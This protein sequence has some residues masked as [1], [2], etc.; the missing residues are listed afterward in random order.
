MCKARFHPLELSRY[1]WT[2]DLCSQNWQWVD[3]LILTKLQHLLND[4]Q[5]LNKINRQSHEGETLNMQIW[6]SLEKWS[7]MFC[8]FFICF[9]SVLNYMTYRLVNIIIMHYHN[10]NDICSKFSFTWILFFSLWFDAW[11]RSN[12]WL[13][14]QNLYSLYSW[15][16]M[17]GSIYAP[18]LYFS[19]FPLSC[20]HLSMIFLIFICSFNSFKSHDR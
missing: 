19:S 6:V 13:V 8:Y 1:S 16:S 4:T 2:I 14:S 17:D 5:S 9:Y 12:S 20:Y 7:S 15:V 10:F 11:I 3:F 18:S